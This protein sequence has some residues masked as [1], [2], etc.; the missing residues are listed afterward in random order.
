MNKTAVYRPKWITRFSEDEDVSC[1]DAERSGRPRTSFTKE[2]C[3]EVEQLIMNERRITVSEIAYQCD[4]SIGSAHE[5][6]KS[7]GFHKLSA[8]W[9]PRLL[10][11]EMKQKRLNASHE[12]LK[13]MNDRNSNFFE[14]LITVDEAWFHQF[15][16]ETKGQSKQWCRQGENPPVKAKQVSSMSKVMVTVF[17]DHE[18]VILIDF[19]DKG[20]TI[21]SEYYCGL[22]RRMREQ[23]WRKRPGKMRMNPILLQDNSRPHVSNRSLQTIAEIGLQTIKHPPY[24]PDL[25]PCDYFL[26]PVMKKPLRGRKFSD[27]DDLKKEIKR[28]CRNQPTE[29]Y[30]D[31]LRKLQE[32]YDKCVRLQGNYVEK[33]DFN[34][35]FDE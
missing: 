8:R 33:C 16:I 28:W 34:I 19:L 35:D 11:S 12:N 29:F 14:R 25:S 31:G 22:L 4:I 7:L 1:N 18:G 17:F 13:M 26:F 6:I 10:T 3:H 21:N 9:V 32:R 30:A 24:S 2:T 20:Q 5:I 23:L 15:E 27:L